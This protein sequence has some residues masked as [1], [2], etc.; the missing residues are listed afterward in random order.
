MNLAWGLEPAKFRAYLI[1]P[2]SACRIYVNLLTVDLAS[3]STSI[4]FRRV[5]FRNL[6]GNNFLENLM[7]G[8]ADI[9]LHRFTHLDALSVLD[10]TGWDVSIE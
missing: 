10:R 6:I 9:G 2:L 7:L 1:S 5:T 3:R 8:L 4:A